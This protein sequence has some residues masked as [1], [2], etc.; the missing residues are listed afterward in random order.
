MLTTATT[1]TRTKRRLCLPHE[2]MTPSGE[3]DGDGVKSG[4]VR[5]ERVKDALNLRYVLSD[6]LP[7]HH[8]R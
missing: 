7:L 4:Q 2:P 6:T 8:L 3:G 5:G 1:P